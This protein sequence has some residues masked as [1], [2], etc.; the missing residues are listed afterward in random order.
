MGHS[1]NKYIPTTVVKNRTNRACYE[2][3]EDLQH[4]LGECLALG[5]TKLRYLELHFLEFATM[6]KSPSRMSFIEDTK[7]PHHILEK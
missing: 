2:N 6:K 4:V 3:E 5:N 1:L 7:S